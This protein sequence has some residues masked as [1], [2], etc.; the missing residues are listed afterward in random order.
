MHHFTRTE[1]KSPEQAISNDDLV[2]FGGFASG[3]LVTVP[4]RVWAAAEA[5]VNETI[6][7][8]NVDCTS[9]VKTTPCGQR[10]RTRV[11]NATSSGWWDL[12]PTDY[13]TTNSWPPSQ[14]GKLG[15]MST[16]ME[17]VS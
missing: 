7:A 6:A 14:L 15:D 3:A 1:G 10:T 13:F 16:V 17:A 11:A 9:L 2:V 12:P 4:E 5:R 8:S